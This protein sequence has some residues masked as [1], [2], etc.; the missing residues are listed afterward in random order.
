[1]SIPTVL[2]SRMATAARFTVWARVFALANVALAMKHHLDLLDDSE[3][4]ELRNLVTQSKGRA[5]NLT[6]SERLRLRE[7]VAKVEP[8]DFAREAVSSMIPLRRGK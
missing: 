3:K 5:A 1:M 4:L 7:L 8:T 2:I 6:E